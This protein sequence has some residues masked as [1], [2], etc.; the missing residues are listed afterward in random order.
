LT[1]SRLRL[2]K[3]AKIHY[4]ESDI[5][6]EYAERFINPIIREPFGYTEWPRNLFNNVYVKEWNNAA[7]KEYRNH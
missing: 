7:M 1:C 4:V 2:E 6:I 3:I 5:I